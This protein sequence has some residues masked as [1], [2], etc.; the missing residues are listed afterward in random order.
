VTEEEVK[1]FEFSDDFRA[2]MRD[3]LARTEALYREGVAGIKYLPEDCQFAVLLAAVLYA[4]HH[5]AIRRC[6]YDVLSETPSLSTGRKLWLLARTRLAWARTK[7]PETVFRRVS[8]VPY[9][10]RHGGHDVETR[11][12]RGRGHRFAA[13]VRNLI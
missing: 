10:G 1:N 2:A 11:P 5:R 9:P 7:E 8:V 6:G 13:W 12:G 4:D 3:E